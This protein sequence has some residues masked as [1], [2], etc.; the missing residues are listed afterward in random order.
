MRRSHVKCDKLSFVAPWLETHV[1]V[2]F[3]HSGRTDMASFTHPFSTN[4]QLPPISSRVRAAPSVATVGRLAAAIR[5]WHRRIREREALAGMNDRE[6][7]DIGV[8]R[9]DA[10]GELAKPF[11]RG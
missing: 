2:V 4:C 3:L 10:L 8:S 5:L 11:W 9:M 7:R 1:A 6:L